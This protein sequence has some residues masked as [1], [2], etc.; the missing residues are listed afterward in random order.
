MG[1]AGLVGIGEGVEDEAV[2]FGDGEVV[3]EVG[4]R[5]GGGGGEEVGEEEGG[6]GGGG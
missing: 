2:V 3:G 4:R 5:V 6:G 1:R